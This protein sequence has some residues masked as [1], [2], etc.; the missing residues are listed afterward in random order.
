[1]RLETILN[2][3][4]KFKSFVYE[5]AKFVVR[6][7]KTII[8]VQLHPRK[9]SR[10]IC[11]SCSKPGGCYDHLSE[12]EFEHVPLW[13]IRV[14]FCYNMR[15]INCKTCGVTVESVPWAHGKE[16][17]TQSMMQFLAGWAK[18]LSWQETARSFHIS[19]HKVFLSQSFFL[20]QVCCKLGDS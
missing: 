8:S 13:G 9:N 10:G 2:F 15:R 18:K 19:W 4:Q 12:R 7:G 3:C 16:S 14:F 6:D 17:M 20:S 1:M 11:S 5:K